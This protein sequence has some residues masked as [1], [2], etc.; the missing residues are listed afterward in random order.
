MCASSEKGGARH[1]T[2]LP[3]LPIPAHAPHPR[4]PSFL[5]R[6]SVILNPTGQVA[7][8]L[9]PAGQVA[10][11][12]NPAGQVAAWLNPAGQVAPVTD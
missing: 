4:A 7:A 1:V 3:T 8:W 6:L 10:A 12:L 5:L 11:W 9:N 2:F